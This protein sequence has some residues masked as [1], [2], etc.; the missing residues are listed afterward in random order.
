MLW[1]YRFFN[2]Y[3]KVKIEGD[4][5]ER[6]I[7][8]CVKS[9]IIL[10]NIKYLKKGIIFL[11]SIKDFKRLFKIRKG[12]K[13][14]IRIQKKYGFPFIIKRYKN[15][16]GIFLGMIFFL[17][18]IYFIS[19]FIWNIEI[20]GNKNISNTQIL[21]ECETLGI[22]I[23]ARKADLNTKILAEKLLINSDKLAWAAFN[24]EGCVLTVDVTETKNYVDNNDDIPTNL[25][26]SQDG[27]I[28]KINV[29]VGNCI[30]KVGQKVNKGDILVSGIIENSYS[31]QF[32]HSVGDI[33][34]VT[35]REY[36]IEEKFN[37]SS[38][39]EI[40]K[41]FK[42]TAISFFGVNIPLYLGEIRNNYIEKAY[43][44]DYLISKKIPIIIY[45]K[46]FRESEKRIITYDKEELINRAQDRLNKKI[47]D[48]NIKD[49]K[50]LESNITENKE[51][52]ILIS[53]IKTEENISSQDIL[54][55]NS[56]K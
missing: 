38:I 16:Y 47:A 13:I 31:T 37:Q 52:I 29:S 28:T 3:V 22:K 15:R 39:A 56:A 49:F 20:N 4:F 55:F 48:D 17:L 8:K 9:S 53:R 10:W 2:G 36:V 43:E 14:K 1:L 40:K 21:Q 45:Q 54:L 12:L 19:G 35:Q 30:V 7:N 42:K 5:P 23:G 24:I 51:S 11:V 34:A 33:F 46:T 41:P 44:K 18:F 6:L 25:K 50:V 26:A 27:V 32:V